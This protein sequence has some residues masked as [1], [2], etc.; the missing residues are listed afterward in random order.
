MIYIYIYD[1]HSVI[2]VYHRCIHNVNGTTTSCNPKMHILSVPKLVQI[3][4]DSVRA[5]AES[6]RD[7]WAGALADY[8]TLDH[9]RVETHIKNPPI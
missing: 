6:K 4:G 9:F 7:K 8:Q 5:Y 2:Y 3:M 1:M